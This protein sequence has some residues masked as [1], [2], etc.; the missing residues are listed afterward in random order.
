MVPSKEKNGSTSQNISENGLLTKKKDMAYSYILMET[1]TRD[2]GL[3]TKEAEREPTGKKS[4][5]NCI[6]NILGIGTMIIFT[7][8]AHSSSL[9]V[10]DMMATGKQIRERETVG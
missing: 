6:E 10:I 8:K 4:L 1:N 3:I 7:E 5:E 9:T 2:H